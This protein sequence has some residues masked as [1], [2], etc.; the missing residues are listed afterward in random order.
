MVGVEAPGLVQLTIGD[1]VRTL[2]DW[3]LL[4]EAQ[5]EGP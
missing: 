1:E 3:Q 2:G 4:D 5:S